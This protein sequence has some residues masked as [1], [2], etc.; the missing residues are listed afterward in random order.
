MFEVWAYSLASVAVVSAI[1]LAGILIFML[2]RELR[3]S[4]LLYLVSFSVGGL[5]GGA[6]FHLIPEAAEASGF[7]PLVASFILLGVLAS[8]IVEQFLKWRHCHVLTSEGHPHSFAYMNLLGDAVHNMIDGMVIGVSYLV[9]TPMGL[10][11]TLA[12]CLHEL[13]QEIGDFGVLLYAGFERRTA[14]LFNLLTALTAFVG[15]VIALALSVYVD[16]LTLFLVPFTAG[17]FIYIAGSDLIPELH[18]EE[19]L[20]STLIQLVA[21]VLGMS[22]LF[23]LKLME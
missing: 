12:V 21:M 1:S 6:F 16:D 20:S 19:T 5:F 13:P 7:T 22:L 11:T 17:N 10:A 23:S 15:V 9:S 8:F 2:G 18:A 4:L 14:L 3:R